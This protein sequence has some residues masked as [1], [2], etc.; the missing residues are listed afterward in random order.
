MVD[1]KRTKRHE[2]KEEGKEK[3]QLRLVR[4][5]ALAMAAA[6]ITIWL[7]IVS[8]E[9]SYGPLSPLFFVTILPLIFI[10]LLLV[11][12]VRRHER[13]AKSGMPL[14]DE[15]SAVIDNKAGRYTVSVMTF[16][17]LAA[18]FYQMFMEELSLPDMPLRYF[19]WVVFF[20]M[21]GVFTAFKWYLGRKEI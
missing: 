5:G 8:I 21:M 11:L 16:F 19:I 17:L 3:K 12:V 18:A 7:S 13:A 1:M 15:R 2:A 6:V 14:T 10:L 4:M 9:M 20:L